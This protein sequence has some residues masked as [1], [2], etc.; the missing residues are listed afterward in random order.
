MIVSSTQCGLDLTVES[1]QFVFLQNNVEDACHSIRIVFG[2]RIGDDFNA[3]DAAR[4]DLFQEGILGGAGQ[5]RWTTV[6]Q[7]LNLR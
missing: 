7:N 1:L 3:V 2:R 6:N 5:S 4:G